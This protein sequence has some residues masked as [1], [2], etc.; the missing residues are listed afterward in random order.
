MDS[1]VKEEGEL[2]IKI[3]SDLIT[4]LTK[5]AEQRR[6]SRTELIE[7][8]VRAHLSQIKTLE[9]VIVVRE[10]EIKELKDKIKPS[11]DMI[12]S[13]IKDLLQ[14][15]PNISL[16]WEYE[17]IVNFFTRALTR[18]DHIYCPIE[19]WR[20]IKETLPS[21]RHNHLSPFTDYDQLC[22]LLYPADPYYFERCLQKNEDIYL[23]KA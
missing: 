6:I 22:R 10:R 1:K 19:A 17:R 20:K 12:T 3:S 5:R 11:Q 15:T 18:F 13:L 9:N 4:E 7:D 23:G 16:G 2:H 21:N 14:Y 8:S